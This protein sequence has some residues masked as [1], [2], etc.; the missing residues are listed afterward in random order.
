MFVVLKS[1]SW[2]DIA[3]NM[4]ASRGRSWSLSLSLR[5]CLCCQM[6]TNVHTR[7]VCPRIRRTWPKA[8]MIKPLPNVATR[9]YR[10]INGR[11]N[12]I[13]N[14]TRKIP[15]KINPLHAPM[16]GSASLFSNSKLQWTRFRPSSNFSLF[17]FLSQFALTVPEK[18]ERCARINKI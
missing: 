4:W 9:L 1:Y 2:K 12:G 16:C 6:D 15:K 7:H 13:R 3:S 17:Y 8:H 14:C 11:F 5:R 10:D 18:K